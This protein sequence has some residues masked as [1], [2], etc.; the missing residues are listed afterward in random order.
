MYDAVSILIEV[1]HASLP[2]TVWRNLVFGRG[3]ACSKYSPLGIC[4]LILFGL[5]FNFQVP[6]RAG[7]YTLWMEE[8]CVFL[9]FFLSSLILSTAPF[10]VINSLWWIENLW[11][12]Q[13]RS[14]ETLRSELGSSQCRSSH[15]WLEYDWEKINKWMCWWE[16]KQQ[17]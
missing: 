5:Y 9:K 16:Q 15:R 17:V 4:V 7:Y 12:R 13:E 14:R 11:Q 8:H 6:W 2:A 10:F 1:S 3:R